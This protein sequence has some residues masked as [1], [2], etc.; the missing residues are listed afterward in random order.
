MYFAIDDEFTKQIT[1]IGSSFDIRQSQLI[2][3][4]RTDFD[5][6]YGIIIRTDVFGGETTIEV[7]YTE[8]FNLCMPLLEGLAKTAIWLPFPKKVS[9]EFDVKNIPEINLVTAYELKLHST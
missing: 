4:G 5:P 2:E 1:I 8:P 9:E 7:G 6:S 3:R